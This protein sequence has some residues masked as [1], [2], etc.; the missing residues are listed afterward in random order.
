LLEF[1]AHLFSLNNGRGIG[2]SVTAEQCAREALACAR[3][4]GDLIGEGTIFMVLARIACDQADYAAAEPLAEQALR[5]ARGDPWIEAWALATA[6]RAALGQGAL[7]EATAAINTAL[8][9]A[10]QQGQPTA[11]TAVLLDALGEL[12]T[13]SEQPH[14][15]WDW[16]IS[17]LDVRY[18]GGELLLIAQ[19][20]DRLAALA[21]SGTQRERALLLAGAADALY[22]KFG[23][24]RTPA[25]QQNVERWLVPLRNA[26]GEQATDD[27]WAQGQALGLEEAI[28]LARSGDKKAAQ[29]SGQEPPAHAASATR[30]GTTGRS[31]RCSLLMCGKMRRGG[32]LPSLRRPTGGI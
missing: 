1:L 16:L 8:S 18:E 31:W 28:T 29:P 30:H 6:G 9:M 21:A 19:T 32:G 14:Q 13:A 25:E 2:A 20:L 22:K 12:A 7:Q 24:R 27:L 15:A 10:R 26:L 23:A 3:A 17:S 5:L 11:I 4:A